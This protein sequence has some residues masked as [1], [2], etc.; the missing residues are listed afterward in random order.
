MVPQGS[1]GGECVATRAA[2]G[3]N[4]QR[5]RD[6]MDEETRGLCLFGSVIGIDK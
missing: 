1:H 5:S 3:H 2:Q 6:L 4:R